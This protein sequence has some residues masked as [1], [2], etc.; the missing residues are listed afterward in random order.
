MVTARINRGE[1]VLA[2]D[3]I[4]NGATTPKESDAAVWPM[5]LVTD[6]D[7]PLGLEVAQLLATSKWLQK[8]T[9]QE[10]IRLETEGIRS[11]L[12]GL[13]AASLEPG[14]FS[15][16]VS[17]E[18]LESLGELLNGPLI[19]RSTPDLFCLDLYKYFD[20]DRLEAVAAP[21]TIEKGRKATLAAPRAP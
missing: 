19:F 17:D 11:Q 7:R 5:M 14:L 8:T 15:T 21:T 12:V 9:G 16:I 2:L 1:Q 10:T 20:I 3:T 13:I 6:G 4:L 18:V